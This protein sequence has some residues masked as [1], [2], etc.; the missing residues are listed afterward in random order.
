MKSSGVATAKNRQPY[1]E[2]SHYIVV[3]D[4]LMM[5]KEEWKSNPRGSGIHG[6]EYGILK[7]ILPLLL[8][9]HALGRL[10]HRK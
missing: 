4:Y 5:K 6:E 1:K 9:D 8:V 2:E 10:W 3:E 7:A